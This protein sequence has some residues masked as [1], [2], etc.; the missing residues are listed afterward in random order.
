MKRYENGEL[1]P[2]KCSIERLVTKPD[3]IQKVIE[4]KKTAVRRND[5]YADPGEVMDL[6]GKRFEITDVYTQTLG[7]VT[8]ADAQAEGFGNLDEYKD[9]IV[10]IH[11]G[12][13]WVP[14]ME[15]WVHE[16]RPAAE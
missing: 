12:M 3:D 5:R 13:K 2:K 4:G 7:E 10:S 14:E 8:D 9:A 15:V 11:H 6:Q 1:P 16:F